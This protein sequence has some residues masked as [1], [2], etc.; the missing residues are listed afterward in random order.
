MK[1]CLLGVLLLFIMYSYGQ[2]VPPAPK[3][4][5]LNF[6]RHNGGPDA[7]AAV[8]IQV[9]CGCGVP[10][11]AMYTDWYIKD[12]CGF[13]NSY[14]GWGY[15]ADLSLN[16]TTTYVA[17]CDKN[18]VK[19][20]EGEITIIVKDVPKYDECNGPTR[21]YIDE[22]V[23]ERTRQ[24][25]H[26]YSREKVICDKT[27]LPGCT[28]DNVFSNLLSNANNTV[29]TGGNIESCLEPYE[30]G[31]IGFSK[32]LFPAQ[33]NLGPINDCQTVIIPRPDYMVYLAIL[34]G[35][36]LCSGLDIR[37]FISQSIHGDP[38]FVKIDSDSKC[39]TNYTLPGHTFYPGKVTRC[40]RDNGC[41][42]SVITVGEGLT[43]I[44]DNFCGRKLAGKNIKKG[45]CIF[46]GVD[47][48]FSINF[49]SQK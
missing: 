42:I 35:D 1:T 12:Y 38:V 13:G 49:D 3:F 45:L 36:I 24:D 39:V 22:A 43:S 6:I 14:L 19:G 41:S 11:C 46:E 10:Q 9:D 21:Q 40:L 17:R 33:S 48:R 44:G 4:K 23:T 15:R 18:G 31:G 16:K 25:Y 34:G 7:D 28:V 8:F 26:Y 30:K 37:K 20:P 29:P 27:L 32:Y 2:E 47:E 5:V